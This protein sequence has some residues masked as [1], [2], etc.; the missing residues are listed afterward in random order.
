MP[1]SRNSGRGL[2]GSS[3]RSQPA[4]RSSLSE[5]E[6]NP[7]T[8]EFDEFVSRRRRENARASA[9]D[10]ARDQD[11][12]RRRVRVAPR[13]PNP[14]SVIPEPP[15]VPPATIEG[16]SISSGES[17]VTVGAISSSTTVSI[18]QDASDEEL[19]RLVLERTRG[20]LPVILSATRL[21]DLKPADADVLLETAQFE[22]SLIIESI[23]AG[24]QRVSTVGLSGQL[25]AAQ[26][27]VQESS[28]LIEERTKALAYMLDALE[29]AASGLNISKM[30]PQI[31]Q[32]AADLL[33]EV[34]AP[35][36]AGN[37]PLPGSLDDYLSLS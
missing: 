18:V 30:S 7:N 10:R 4:A 36:E 2:P 33:S 22:K 25:S 31:M 12:A 3:V 27:E 1:I 14:T 20:P 8:D 9:G 35:T 32:R 19:K 17:P 23:E 28:R 5:E 6:R 11:R 13:L 16:I 29:T 26:E 21:P 34:S 24:L 37:D 15:P